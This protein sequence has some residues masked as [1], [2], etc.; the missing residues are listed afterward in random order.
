M[1]CL[2]YMKSYCF[3]EK[4][5]SFKEEWWNHVYHTKSEH[6]YQLK[7]RVPPPGYFNQNIAICDLTYRFIK[8]NFLPVCGFPRFFNMAFS[9]ATFYCAKLTI[10]VN[11]S[12]S[13]HSFHTSVTYVPMYL[14]WPPCKPLLK[15]FSVVRSPEEL[16]D[17]HLISQWVQH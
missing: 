12:L 2:H 8:S 17:I 16:T 3:T 14:W 10:I 4:G 1:Y 15:K 6:V 7:K 9:S 5:Y 13:R 11:M